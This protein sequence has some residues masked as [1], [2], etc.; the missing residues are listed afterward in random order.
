[1]KSNFLY[2]IIFWYL[3]AQIIP[4]ELKLTV[5]LQTSQLVFPIICLNN[6][7]NLSC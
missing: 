1:M 2:E 5:T 4:N 3:D 6:V 7:I